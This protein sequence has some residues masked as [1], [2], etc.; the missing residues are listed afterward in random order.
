MNEIKILKRLLKKKVKIT[1]LL[2]TV[3]FI[4]GNITCAI[5]ITN[6]YIND[7]ILN[8]NIN[9]IETTAKFT[10]NGLIQFSKFNNSVDGGEII[11]NG[12]ILDTTFNL[13]KGIQNFSNKGTIFGKNNSIKGKNTANILN[14]GIIDATI[15]NNKNNTAI[16]INLEEISSS[17]LNSIMNNGFIYGIQGGISFSGSRNLR[18][19]I[20][21]INIF[22]NRGIISTFVNGNESFMEYIAVQ[23]NLSKKLLM[24]LVILKMLVTLD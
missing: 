9:L 18:K 6:N 1:N 7:G 11:N 2:L 20:G 24:K 13:S 12:L 3:F 22:N 21:D 19:T 8:E 17:K 15:D 5:D 16:R 14:E 10:N 23:L 4:T